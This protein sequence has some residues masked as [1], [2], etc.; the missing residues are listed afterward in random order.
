MQ[1][2]FHI[3][4]LNLSP[5]LRRQFE[6]PLEGLKSLIS[7]SAAAVVLEHR[8]DDLPPFRAYACLAVPGPDIHADARDYTLE[9]AW[10]KVTT[11]MRR[12]VLQHRSRQAAR[13]KGN[14]QVH[15]RA[16]RLPSLV[17]AR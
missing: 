2:Q 8:R 14:G 10:L 6:P 12:Q 15:A 7:I 13:V 17:A 5:T 1:I 4:G 3:R 16:S 9:A 11:A